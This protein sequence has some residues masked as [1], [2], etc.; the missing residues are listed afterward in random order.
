MPDIERGIG[1]RI[2]TRGSPQTR[3][4]IGRY[5]ARAGL[6]TSRL[7]QPRIRW[8]RALRST[9]LTAKSHRHFVAV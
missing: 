6:R 4:R 3:C 5:R 9:R 8:R 2:E 1:L 7:P